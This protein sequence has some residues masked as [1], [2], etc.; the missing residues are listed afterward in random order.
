MTSS[1]DLFSRHG[2][3]AQV[4]ACNARRAKAAGHLNRT[5]ELLTE[6][7]AAEGGYTDRG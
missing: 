7:Y 5:I 1:Q 3:R 6:C 4:P 2:D